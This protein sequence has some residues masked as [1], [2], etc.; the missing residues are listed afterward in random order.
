MLHYGEETQ[1]QNEV[2]VNE[3]YIEAFDN[4]IGS[5]VVVPGKYSIPFLARVKRRKRDALVNPIG[6]E[7]S[8]PILVTR[9]YELE[10]PDWRVDE[11]VVNIII[12]NIIDHVDDQG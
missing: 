10:F 1:Y 4:Y 9:I 8:K 3:D 12:E 2:K 5:K 6:E 7:H 11:Y